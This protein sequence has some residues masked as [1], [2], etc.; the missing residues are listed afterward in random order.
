[1]FQDTK[2]CAVSR[3]LFFF[4]GVTAARTQLYR[5][6]RSYRRGTSARDRSVHERWILFGVV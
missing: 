3:H 4:F 6:Q 1:M 2:I 5:T